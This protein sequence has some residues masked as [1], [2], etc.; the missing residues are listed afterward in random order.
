MLNYPGYTPLAVVGH[1]MANILRE[2]GFSAKFLHDYTHHK[3]LAVLA[4][5]GSY[6]KNSLIISPKHGP[7]LRFGLVITD[8]KL[9]YDRPFEKD[10]CEACDRCVK[11]CPTGALKPYV[12]DPDKC[13]VAIGELDDPP[14]RFKPV[15][16]K[17]QLQLTPHTHV[18]CT[19]CQMVCPYTPPERRRAVIRKPRAPSARAKRTRSGK[20]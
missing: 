13:L 19:R 1:M 15:L 16:S 9:P 8:A 5:L 14:S 10:L 3:T 17:H 18:M 4:G 7:W 11:A 6:G 12:V 2:E 20:E